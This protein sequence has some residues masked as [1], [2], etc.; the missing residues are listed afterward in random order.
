MKLYLPPSWMLTTPDQTKYGRGQ[1]GRK[2]KKVAEISS[3][4]TESS[5]K[6]ERELQNE[7]NWSIED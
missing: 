3:S 4:E 2:K 6:L 1:I 7:E 5:R